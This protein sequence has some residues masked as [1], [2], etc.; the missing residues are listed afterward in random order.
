VLLFYLQLSITLGTVVAS[1]GVLIHL[2]KSWTRSA[3]REVESFW[4]FAISSMRLRVMCWSNRQYSQ[5]FGARHYANAMLASF[6][7]RMP[8]PSRGRTFLDIEHAYIRLSLSSSPDQR[9]GDE[10]LLTEPGSVLIFGEPG[11]GKSSLTRKLFRESLK[12][13]YPD[14]FGKRLPLHVELGKLPWSD[15]PAEAGERVEWLRAILRSAV[16][17]VSGVDDPELLFRSFVEGPGLIV[18]L[19]G[20]DEIPS[21]CLKAAQSLISA[22]VA[23]LLRIS[24]GTLVV[25][26][27]RTQL[28]S[29]LD[30]S[31]VHDFHQVLTVTPFTPADVFAFLR[32]WEFPE[33]RR[34][35]EIHRIFDHLR[36]NVTLSA[37]CTNPLVLAMYVAEDELHSAGTGSAVRLADTRSRFYDQVVGELLYFRREEQRKRAPRSMQLLATRAELIGRIALDHLLH[38]GDPANVVSLKRA[39]RIAQRYWKV[40]DP[41]RAAAD[42]VDLAVETGLVS[43]QQQGESLQFI[44]LSICEYLAGKELAERGQRQLHTAVD[45][46]VT[47]T[48]ESRRRW[49]TL[50]FA[51]ALS[52][53]QVRE[54][55]LRQLAG[56]GIP[57]ELALRVIRELQAYDQPVFRDRVL[58]ATAEIADRPPE[59]WDEDWLARVRLV[60]S[61][62]GD[63]HRLAEVR[64]SRDVPTVPEW[65]EELVGADQDRFDRIFGL[66]LAVSPAEAL[67]IADEF[68]V[69]D[70]LFAD[71]ERIVAALEHPDV[72]ALG[73]KMIGSGGEVS[74]AWIDVMAEAALRFE[75]VAQMLL[76]ERDVPET[77]AER[78]ESVEPSHSWHRFGIAAGTLY[79]VVLALAT[80]RTARGRRISYSGRVDVVALVDPSRK[81]VLTLDA[82]TAPLTPSLFAAPLA[83]GGFV[84]VFT[85]G[86]IM[87]LP[88]PS[89]PGLVGLLPLGLSAFQIVKM[90][91]QA[92]RINGIVD[93]ATPA[94]LLNL[95]ADPRTSGELPDHFVA[96]FRDGV[97]RLY[98]PASL[99]DPNPSIPLAK[100]ARPV[101]GGFEL[102]DPR[103]R[104]LD[105]GGPVRL[106]NLANFVPLVQAVSICRMPGPYACTTLDVPI[107]RSLRRPAK[108]RPSRLVGAGAV[109][110]DPPQSDERQNEG[111]VAVPAA[112][113]G[114]H[115]VVGEG[116]RVRDAQ[117]PDREDAQ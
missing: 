110:P 78:V 103:G 63:A 74:D 6:S 94:D 83:I 111:D 97:L 38:S 3:G 77:L 1:A 47:N 28:R 69:R 67:R 70:R 20:L 26:T 31:F 53:R 27:A 54:D 75:L 7:R 71:G 22:T 21:E 17:G 99:A 19:D 98:G 59:Q 8:I 2:R 64:P 12:Q 36:S 87:G 65:L 41:D 73:L 49:E 61:C 107:T 15:V 93:G 86:P 81:P 117:G 82:L 60:V 115:R 89:W 62:L 32:R 85:Y 100:I 48:A 52:N 116:D 39:A 80:A 10:S 106:V 37:M 9:V 88:F 79:G 24:S 57:T 96:R 45:A 4:F 50:I 105:N 29:V 113:V 112:V 114:P 11:S 46:V 35:A 109:A 58:T 33:N 18:F 101:L 25:V 30:R 90:R 92:Q 23:S 108:P 34:L 56:P 68:G 104:R 13:V 91:G 51:I 95:G 76:E 102:S 14:P 72:I 40:E 66:Y 84:L 55:V 42:L 44:H 5:Q 43:V 16:E